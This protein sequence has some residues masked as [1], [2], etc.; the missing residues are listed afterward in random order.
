MTFRRRA[1]VKSVLKRRVVIH[2]LTDQSLQGVLMERGS[3][4]LIVRAGRLLG[5]GEDDGSTPLAGEVWVPFAQIAFCQL[6][7]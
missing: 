2:L 3:D 1:W 5:E 7:E 4:G 6:D